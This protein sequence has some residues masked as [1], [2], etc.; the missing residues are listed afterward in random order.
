MEKIS[1]VFPGKNGFWHR[2][3]GS[4]V[5]G[6][7]VC[8]ILLSSRC[9]QYVVSLVHPCTP[10]CGSK[11][12]LTD[13]LPSPLGAFYPP[14]SR[15]TDLGGAMFRALHLDASKYGYL[16]S[17]TYQNINER[18]RSPEAMSVIYFRSLEDLH[19]FAHDEVHMKG[20]KWWSGLKEKERKNI[21]IAHEVF[22]APEGGWE[23]AYENWGRSGFGKNS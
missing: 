2:E 16:G 6:G 8:I 13:L 21:A 19:H 3:K 1:A 22:L 9:N 5:G 18:I 20:V 17:S 10:A 15:M 14:F 4:S 12:A 7:K 23:T 11:T